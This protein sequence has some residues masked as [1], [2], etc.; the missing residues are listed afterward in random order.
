MTFLEILYQ[1]SIKICS[2]SNGYNCLPHCIIIKNLIS[3]LYL[4]RLRHFAAQSLGSLN[5]KKAKLNK[6]LPQCH[7]K[8]IDVNLL[9]SFRLNEIPRQ[10]WWPFDMIIVVGASSLHNSLEKWRNI[11][12]RLRLSK[13]VITKPGYNLHPQTAEKSKVQQR[14]VK[15]LPFT[16]FCSNNPLARP[17]TKSLT[18]PPSNLRTPLTANELVN[19]VLKLQ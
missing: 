6:Y 9:N 1:L 16:F 2:K 14:R 13:Q 11:S 8:K 4:V 17:N 3:Q 15:F 19:E 12:Q 7:N 18:H 10:P 5:S